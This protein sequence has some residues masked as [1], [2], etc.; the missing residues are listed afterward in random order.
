MKAENNVAVKGEGDEKKGEKIQKGEQVEGTGLERTTF[1][2]R[3][4]L[5]C[6]ALQSSLKCSR[7]LYPT[8]ASWMSIS[9]QETPHTWF[10]SQ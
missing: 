1:R 6:S 8:R 3:C 5:P 9:A 2:E 10:A 4:R 7:L